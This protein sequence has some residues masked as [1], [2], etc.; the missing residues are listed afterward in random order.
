[1]G[2][3]AMHLK[4]KQKY[5]ICIQRYATVSFRGFHAYHWGVAEMWWQKCCRL[6]TQ[7]VLLKGQEDD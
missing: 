5:G 4:L 2:Y 7:L 3:R 6:W 1:M